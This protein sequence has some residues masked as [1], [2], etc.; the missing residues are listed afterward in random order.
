MDLKWLHR[1]SEEVYPDYRETDLA[2]MGG[3]LSTLQSV[4]GILILPA[5]EGG[6]GNVV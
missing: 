5:R 1:E 4:R 6:G 3:M 2:D